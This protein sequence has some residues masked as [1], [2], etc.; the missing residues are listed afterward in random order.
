MTPPDLQTWLITQ[1]SEKPSLDD[2]FNG[3]WPEAGEAGPAD[4]ARQYRPR[5]PAPGGDRLLAALIDGD[6]RDRTFSR[7]RP[8]LLTSNSY[9]HSP[10]K[11]VDDTNQP[12]RWR[13]GED[14]RGMEIIADMVAEDATE[15]MMLP[16]AF[17]TPTVP[18]PSRLQP[19]RR[20]VSAMLDSRRCNTRAS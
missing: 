17:R 15:Y 20:V 3:F 8:G 2:L 19:R 1:I 11:F 16:L 6:L 5:D 12:F 10:A 14:D 9:L 13:Q 4:L 7:A 18:P